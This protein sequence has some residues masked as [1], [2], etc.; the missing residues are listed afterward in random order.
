[1]A[2]DVTAED[3]ARRTSVG[4]VVVRDGAVQWTNRAAHDLVAPHGG[5]WQGASTVLHLL[6]G[7]RPG[8]RREAL[9][10]PSPVGGTRWWEVSC[11]L[12]EPTTMGLLY[13]I[14]DETPRQLRE[15][16]NDRWRLDRLEAI[17]GMG[18]WEWDP[19][20]GIAEYS[21]SLLRLLG[22]PPGTTRDRTGFRD[23]IHPDDRA[24]VDAVLAEALRTG[25][26]F[27]YTHRMHSYDRSTLRTF[28]C[29][30]EVFTDA[31]GAPVR[32]LGAV[33]DV[34]EQHR[35]R[36]E[37]AFLADHDPLTGIAN[38]RRITGR[39]EECLAD[40]RG[41]ALLLVDV[42]NFKDI[43]DIRGHAAGDRV[44]RTLARTLGAQIGPDALLGRLGGD[45]FAVV[46]PACGAT[47]AL[48][49]GE[50]LCAAARHTQVPGEGDALRVS[51]SV[52]VAAFRRGHDVESAMAQADLALYEAKGSG[53]DRARLFAP[54]QYDQALR[55]VSVLERVRAGLD[56]GTMTFDAQPIVDL[57]TGTVARH[58][59]LIRLRDGL[60]PVL[61]P[62]EFLPAAERTDLVLRLDRW[63]LER[64]I[65]ALATPWALESHLRLE[66]N[67]SAR[68][69]D[70]P[71]LGAWILS[72]LSRAD[73][74]PR[75][76]G[77]EITETAAI[78]SID[79]ARDLACRLTG[80]G[81][82]FTLD[83]FG[84]GFGSFSHLKHLP[85]T[86]IKIAGDFVRQ[87]DTEPVD[88]ALVGAV[89]GVAHQLGI[90][91][92]AEQVDRPPLVGQLRGLGVAQGQGY[93]LG[94]PK[95]LREVLA[96]L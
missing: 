84:A 71:E 25:E 44:M 20:D 88:R 12:L 57:R 38:R 54:D 76:L 42:D 83:D 66:V 2:A 1:M 39:L 13:E 72:V 90:V 52:G 24:M 96:A 35:A 77:L 7:V 33:R 85:F 19:L 80:A 10:W 70:D 92:V 49:L 69:L 32:V 9:R 82:G 81:C 3:V 63:V 48:D 45:E 68:S 87:L 73:V 22:V 18:S 21:D 36:A 28:E 37:L 95:P 78:A 14:T 8:T 64:A 16:R 61:G 23:L 29:H 94:R 47:D 43:N 4:L 55:R 51:I 60:E 5:A 79:A 6:H 30:G 56:H 74:D 89:V 53:R 59:L 75:R 40:E 86:G 11:R 15:D 91:T 31:S 34:T 17:A 41:V 50:R 58:E 26:P 65:A 67:V 27:T 93:H 46:V 62:A